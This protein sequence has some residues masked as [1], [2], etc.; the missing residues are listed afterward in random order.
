M[1]LQVAEDASSGST[2]TIVRAFVDGVLV[3]ETE[4]SAS[5]LATGSLQIDTSNDVEIHEVRVISL[6]SAAV[7]GQVLLDEPFANLPADWTFSGT[8]SIGSAMGRRILDVSRL[9][10]LSLD[11]EYIYQHQ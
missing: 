7:T 3:L 2:T 8:W 1:A 9:T 6:G 5:P 10:A 11:L 4:D